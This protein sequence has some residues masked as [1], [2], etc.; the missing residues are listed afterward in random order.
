MAEIGSEF[1]EA[2]DTGKKKYLISGRAAL[3]YIIR[4]IL[5]EHSVDS[6]LMPSY[7][8]YTMLEPFVRHGIKIRFY[9]IFYDEEKAYALNCRKRIIQKLSLIHI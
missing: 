2:A 1:W 3:E 5:E 4:D 8:C 9:D 6:V 7:C